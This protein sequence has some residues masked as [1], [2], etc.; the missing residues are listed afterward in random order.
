AIELDPKNA[1]YHMNLAYALSRRGDSGGAVA[2]ARKAVE[3]APENPV[4]H[5]ELANR[6]GGVKRWAE[7]R[8]VLADAMAKLPAAFADPRE[9]LRYNAACFAVRMGD[10]PPA[11]D[12]LTADLAAWANLLAADPAANA[13]LVRRRVGDWL[14]D[15]DLV[16]VRDPK[17]LA[18]LPAGERAEWGK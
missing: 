1:T 17:L 14:T 13:P 3:L 16:S 5:N 6:L 7:A 15:D 11:L 2:A 10:R 12:W 18:A 4:M 9:L 8:A